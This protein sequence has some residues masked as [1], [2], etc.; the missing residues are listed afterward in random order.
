MDLGLLLMVLIL[1]I[2][3]ST[4][5]L[6]YFQFRTDAIKEDV[7]KGLPIKVLFIFS[8]K[9]KPAFFELFMY[10]AS[11]KRGS[12]LYLPQNIGVI[13]EKL[14]R[15]D[16]IGMLYDRK[17]PK[18]LVEEVGKLLD[19]EIN[20]YVDLSYDS[21]VK[22]VDLLGG[23]DLFIPNP[24]NISYDD[25]KI[26]LPSGSV[27]LFGDKALEFITYKEKHEPEI[28]IIGRK[29]KFLQSLLKGLGNTSRLLSG[30]RYFDMFKSYLRTNLS[31]HSL[32]SLLSELGKMDSER[33]IFQRSLGT[34]KDVDGKKLLF[35]HY[36]GELLREKVKQTLKTIASKD[37]LSEEDLS[38]TIEILNGTKVNGLAA[39]TRE[40]YQSFGYDVISIGNTDNQYLNTVV[41]DRKG[42]LDIAKKVASIIHCER[43]YTR[44]DPK[45]DDAI[46][47]TI[48]LGKDFDGRYCRK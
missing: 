40:I 35:P 10:D 42:N 11:T 21:V 39:R 22:I 9:D 45:I 14:K 19:T 15:V 38:V 47:V 3:L 4:V 43:I 36:D 46:E 31:D 48:I 27:T 24:V 37:V 41:L 44:I 32:K 28:D 25:Q 16:A 1:I 17:N 8:R 2:L 30:K 33:L 6:I 26:L 23:I 5:L 7:K 34:V 18:P 20:Y 29:Q 13:I 12:I